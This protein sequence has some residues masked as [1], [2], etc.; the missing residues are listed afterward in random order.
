M[1]RR[2]DSSPAWSSAG[3]SAT[4]TCT[5]RSSSRA[6]QEQCGF[7]E[8]EL[9]CI[10]VEAQ[11]LGRP[12][13]ALPDRRREDRC[14]RRGAGRRS[15]TSSARAALGP[16]DGHAT[17]TRSSSAAGPT[18]SPRRSR[19]RRRRLGAGAR[20]RRRDRGRDAHRRAHA[21]R[22]P[23]RRLLGAAIR[24][25]SSRRSCRTLPLAGSTGS[26]GCSPPASVAHPLD[27][28]PA[29]ML[30]RS[31]EETARGLGADGA[32]YRRLVAPF[33]GEPQGFLARRP[34]AAR[35]HP[36]AIRC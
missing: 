2:R 25:A 14:A 3:T 23:A 24:W 33:L 21:A 8:G 16:R 29:V 10:F 9:R 13:L 22:L 18:A 11:P 5:T 36:A 28:G 31:V 4:G 17:P 32:R 27:D 1:G 7:E 6:V 30:W 26:T 12:T 35:R 20:G 19:W 34:R 15:K